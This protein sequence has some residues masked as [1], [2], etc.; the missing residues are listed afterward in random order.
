[1]DLVLI[2]I[3]F[4]MLAAGAAFQLLVFWYLVIGTIWKALRG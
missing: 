1:M 3:F 2:C 4:A